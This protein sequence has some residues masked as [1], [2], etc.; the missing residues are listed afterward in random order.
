MNSQSNKTQV[1]ILAMAALN[2][3]GETENV[4]AKAF[5]FAEQWEQELKKRQT[6]GKKTRVRKPTAK[7]TEGATE[8]KPARKSRRKAKAETADDSQ[9]KEE[10]TKKSSRRSRKAKATE[11]ATEEKPA[12]KSRRG[13]QTKASS[14]KAPRNVA[15][16]GVTDRVVETLAKSGI[17]TVSQLKAKTHAEMS[18][19]S[20]LGRRSVR[21][22][23][24][25]LASHGLA[26]KASK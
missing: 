26:F 8:E 24:D 20:G 22:V 13:T 23:K 1:S 17:K 4:A 6:E 21:A 3:S 19:I 25:A 11:G 18:D 10:A 5:D 9:P 7:A 15:D 2:E 12:R 16:L 14:D